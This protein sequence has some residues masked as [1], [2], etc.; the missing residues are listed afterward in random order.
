MKA[1]KPA[2]AIIS[3]ILPYTTPSTLQGIEI[4]LMTADVAAK[5]FSTNQRNHDDA[6]GFLVVL[7]GSMVFDVDFEPQS[8]EAGMGF[9]LRPSQAY[10]FVRCTPDLKVIAFRVR[11]NMIPPQVVARMN[12]LLLDDSAFP[13]SK[14]KID[15]ISEIFRLLVERVDSPAPGEWLGT[16]ASIAVTIASIITEALENRTHERYAQSQLANLPVLVKL[17]TYFENH[18][19]QSRLP[20]HYAELMGITPSYLN[21]LVKSVVGV[22]VSL[23]VRNE[24]MRIIRRRLVLTNESIHNIACSLGYDDPAYLSRVFTKMQGMTPTQFRAKYSSP[25]YC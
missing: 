14:A 4:L 23:Y 19:G 12:Y 9:I 22:N 25:F 17:H 20:S 1:P 6:F 15:E 24:A 2:T 11:A 8:S 13:V 5:S 18:L 10:R 7:K 21:E 3:D 16:A